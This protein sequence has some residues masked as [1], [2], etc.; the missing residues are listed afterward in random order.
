MLNGGACYGPHFRDATG[1]E[2]L[3]SILG[4]WQTDSEGLPEFTENMLDTVV[5]EFSHS[6]A[7]PIIDRH[8]E[9]LGTAGDI[10]F[11]RVAGKMRSQAYGEP[12]TMLRESLVRASVIRYLLHYNGAG[13]AQRA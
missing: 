6:Y 10:L 1:N 2:E 5:H 7:N 13:A 8:Q 4:V 12:A 3:F 11:R 9:A